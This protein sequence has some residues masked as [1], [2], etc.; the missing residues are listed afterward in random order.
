MEY[1]LYAGIAIVGVAI[2]VFFGAL[3]LRSSEM[4]DRQQKHSSLVG[5]IAL[6]VVA[7]LII[8]GQDAASW[9]AIAALFIGFGAGK[10]PVLHRALIHRWPYLKATPGT[11]GKGRG[12][13]SGKQGRR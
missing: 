3:P 2:G 10:I 1:V 7:V 5:M 8:I 11:K 13:G 4:N 9:I 12:K 6:G